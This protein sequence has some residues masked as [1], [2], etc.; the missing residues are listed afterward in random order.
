MERWLTDT[1]FA[2][3]MDNC[4][5]FV[6]KALMM[7][8]ISKRKI[9]EI[10]KCLTGQALYQRL[11]VLGRQLESYPAGFDDMFKELDAHCHVE[12]G[13]DSEYVETHRKWLTV[14]IHLSLFVKLS[15]HRT[16]AR[17]RKY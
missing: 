11:L 6:G 5:P 4:I 15:Q 7:G 17:C 2:S 9:T 13:R 16:K 10:L 8:L 14:S 3:R 1:D 12:Y